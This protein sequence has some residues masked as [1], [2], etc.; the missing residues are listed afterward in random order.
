MSAEFS[1]SDVLI[2][3]ALPLN[4]LYYSHYWE[5]P[6]TNWDKIDAMTNDDIDT[7]D[8]P[9]LTEEF[10]STAKL[11]MPSTPISTVAVRV[12]SETFEWFRSKGE[13]S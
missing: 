3:I 1:S 12:D 8:I 6:R 10:F 5:A 4:H 11:R 13:E 2:S 7:S 9:P